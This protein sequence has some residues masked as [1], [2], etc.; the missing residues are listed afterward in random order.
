MFFQNLR[1]FCI[2][3]LKHTYS[4]I[5]VQ[6]FSFHAS[7][8]KKEIIEKFENGNQ[9]FIVKIASTLSFIRLYFRFNSIL[10]SIN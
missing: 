2:K 1:N 9:F 8:E 7:S 6:V 5:H 10:N 4:L 3:T